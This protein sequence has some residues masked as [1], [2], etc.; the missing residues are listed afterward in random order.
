MAQD[1]KPHQLFDL[2]MHQPLPASN[3]AKTNIIG[4]PEPNLPVVIIGIAGSTVHGF[5]DL[6][7]VCSRRAIL[8]DLRHRFIC[9]QIILK[10]QRFLHK[11]G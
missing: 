4:I 3:T 10:K 8:T 9:L 2:A 1:I 5:I 11:S 6:I 7:G